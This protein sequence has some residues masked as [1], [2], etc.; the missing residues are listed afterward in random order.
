MIGNSPRSDINP[1][2]EAGINA[3]YVPHPN[4]WELE[5]EQVNHTAQVTVLKGFGEL[6]SLFPGS[7]SEVG[8]PYEALLQTD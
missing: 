4:T 3:I 6:I 1:A 8:G 2:V 5:L 7:D